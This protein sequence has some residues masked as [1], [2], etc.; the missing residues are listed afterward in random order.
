MHVEIGAIIVSLLFFYRSLTY[1]L[2]LQSQWNQFIAVSGSLDNM[3]SFERDLISKHEEDGTTE[4][5]GLNNYIVLEDVNLNYGETLALKGLNLKIRKNEV[6]GL[7]GAS[8]SGKT[9]LINLLAGL[10]PPDRG[11]LLVDGI[12]LF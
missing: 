9:S 4:F 2:A 12:D 6:I 3:T 10:I 8:G 1:L 7:V 5:L 11:K